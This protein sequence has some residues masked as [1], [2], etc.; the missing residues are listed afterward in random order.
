MWLRSLIAALLMW[1][2]SA[3]ALP[4]G[5]AQT[6]IAGSWNQVAGLAFS[7]DGSRLYVVERGG[8]V[9]I[10]ENGTKLPT[11]FLDL[12]DEVGGWRDFGLL[13][14]ALH[15]NFEVNGFVYALYVVDRY[16]LFNS[17]EPDY[18]PAQLESEQ[19]QATIGRIA[20]FTADPATGMRTVL[21]G[22]RLLL[23]GAAVDDGIPILHESHGT[24]QLVFGQDGTLLA[25]NGD[26]ASYS[27]TDVGSAVETYYQQAL[28][29]EI[30]KPWENI[31]AYRSQMIDAYNGNVL[32]IDPITGEGIPSNPWYDPANPTSVRSRSFAVGLRNPYRFTHRPETGSHDPA[33]GDPGVF[34]IGDVGWGSAEDLHVLSQAGQNFGWPAFE[35]LTPHAGYTNSSPAHPFAKNPLFGDPAYPACTQEYLRIRDLIIQESPSPSWPNP[36]D[37]AVEIPDF[38]IDPADQALYRYDKHEH[39]RPPIAWRGNANVATYDAQGNATT[40]QMGSG[41]PVAGPDFSGNASTGG[42]WYTGTDFPETWRDTYFHADYG[43]GW[44]KNFVFDGDDQLLEVR[45]FVDPGNRVTF[46]ATNPTSGGIYYVKWGDRVRE[47]RYVGEGNTAPQAIAEPK[48]SSGSSPLQVQFVG[49]GSFDIDAGDSLSYFWEFGDGATSEEADPAHTYAGPL[50]Q[51]YTVR[52]T[53][54]DGNLNVDDDEVLVSLN[55]TPPTVVIDSPIDGSLYAMAT[56]TTYPLSA[57]I[58]DAEHV[59]AEMSCT[60]QVE[61]VHNDHTH[62]EPP[63]HLCGS[64]FEITPV[65]CDGNAYAWRMTLTVT[66]AEGLSTT[67]SAEVLPDCS[68]LPNTPPIALDD[69]A[70]VPQGLSAAIDVLANDSDLDGVLDPSSVTLTDLP[71]HGTASVDPGTGEVTYSHDGSSNVTDEFAYRVSDED[72]DPSNPATVFV[73]TFNNPPMAHVISP[74]DG[75][76]YAPGELLVLEAHGMD[77]EQGTSVAFDWQVDAIVGSQLIPAVFTWTGPAPPLFDTSS[78]GTPGDAVSYAISVTVTDGVGA[79]ATASARVIPSDPPAGNQPPSAD[80]SASPAIGSVPLTVDFDASASS[81]PDGDYLTYAWSFGD[82][83]SATGTFAAHTYT[84]RGNYV[85][86]LEVMDSAGQVASASL[87]IQVT[88]TGLTGTYVN[89]WT[90]SGGTLDVSSPALIRTD[91]VVDFDWGGGSPDPSIASD[92]FGVRWEGSIRPEFTEDYQFFTT[93]DDGVRLWVDGQLLIDHWL[94]QGPTERTGPTIS[95]VAGQWYPIV[96]E[97]FENGIGAFAQL[98]WA[99]PSQAKQLVPSGRL[100]PLFGENSGPAVV[101][102]LESVAQS[103]QVVIGVLTNDIDEKGEIDP[104]SVQVTTPPTAGTAVPD[105]GSG[106]IT[107]T[108]DGTFGG[109]DSFSY[110]VADLEG[111]VSSDALVTISVEIPPPSLTILNLVD[112]STLVGPDLTVVYQVAGDPDAFDHLHLTLDDPPHVTI[113]DLTGTYTFV[114]PGLGPH[115]L[116]AQLVESSHVAVANP[117]ARVQLDLTL[118]PASV[119]GDSVV[120]QSEQ[121]DD[122]NLDPGDCCSPTCSYEI[123]DSVCEADS[124]PCTRDVC[125]GAGS[126]MHPPQEDGFTCDDAEP[127]T[128]LDQCVAGVCGGTPLPDLDA[129]GSCNLI[130]DDDDGDGVGD[131]LDSDPLDPARCRD[132]DTDTCDDCA[133]GPADPA[134]DGTDSD[135]DGFCDLGDN[136]AWTAN[137]QLDSGSYGANGADG[138]GD[139]CQCGAI[140]LDGHLG[141]GDIA[142]LREGLAD[143]AGSGLT[144]QEADLCSVWAD[145]GCDLADLVVMRRAMQELTPGLSQTCASATP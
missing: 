129:D 84:E 116:T 53:V 2:A 54:T 75:S 109:S 55:N 46:V 112:G 52:L 65:G 131:A 102:D 20:R 41:T 15:P 118:V 31:G 5:F 34:Y 103:G 140:E 47:I 92:D 125:D 28:D 91:P 18:D 145:T 30:L 21:P 69:F 71:F 111:A 96:M 115:T 67:R 120:E 80:F 27:S 87:L 50:L 74:A 51:S 107:Y 44:I 70:Q 36:C 90:L 122:G 32:R 144:S 136:C 4:P 139:A 17:E 99:S 11:P 12:R 38:W 138:I 105:P 1:P 63:I 25:T 49:S 119:C 101:P 24:G 104:A 97:Y 77:P 135:A 72:G 108:H 68:S 9:W 121:C 7:E 10:V 58:S 73:S 48:Q 114:A 22:S 66:D 43:A 98:R 143:P 86:S 127:C 123:A 141:S 33:D 39:A 94:P 89:D 3:L 40:T 128:E 95:L 8:L 60:W 106:A 130:D 82:A 19:K 23:V 134:N 35:G 124:N 61:L 14:F 26:G 85:A 81:D 83:D 93:T 62:P 142:R 56:P 13:G 110:T 100:A 57:T 64:S 59:P 37:G 117:E 29:D 137:D 79:S 6:E 88:E 132:T 133:L 78:Q 42:V 126:C 113:T 45:N 76:S 16:H